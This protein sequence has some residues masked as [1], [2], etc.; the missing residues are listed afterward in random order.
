MA[1][2]EC[3]H[4]L[5]TVNPHIIIF[6]NSAISAC[7]GII[8]NQ[9]FGS[10]G[11]YAH[12]S[13]YVCCRFRTGNDTDTR[14]CFTG[15]HGNGGSRTTRISTASAVC[16]SGESFHFRNPRVFIDIKNLRGNTQ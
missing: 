12:D 6:I 11:I 4:C 10:A 3:G 8:R 1:T 15:H 16:T 13:G 5:T 9:G 2:G 7:T 14:R